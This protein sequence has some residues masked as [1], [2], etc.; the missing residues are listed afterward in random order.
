[1]PLEA[2]ALTLQ[3]VFAQS[4][5]EMI[6]VSEGVEVRLL[7]HLC[8]GRSG[9]K[10]GAGWEHGLEIVRREWRTIRR[11]TIPKAAESRRIFGPQPAQPP[12]VTVSCSSTSVVC[13]CDVF[14]K[15]KHVLSAIE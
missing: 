12:D 8:Y 6:D 3:Y 13:I 7:A 1:M 4:S 2:C 15:V 9:V 11:G 5:S 14:T 10:V